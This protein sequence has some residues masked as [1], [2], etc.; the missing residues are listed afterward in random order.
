M[1][2]ASLFFALCLALPAEEALAEASVKVVRI[3]GDEGTFDWAVQESTGR[4]FASCPAREEV[5]EYDPADGKTL[6]RFRV[7]G[8]PGELLVKKDWLLVACRQARAVAVVD[9]AAN[10]V[11]GTI[12]LEGRSPD[13]LFCCALDQPFAYARCAPGE[14]GSAD[15][16]FQLELPLRTVRRRVTIRTS[17][18]VAGGPA[19]MTTDGRWVLVEARQARTSSRVWSC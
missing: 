8:A 15:E 9:L 17:S 13:A 1:P 18:K 14:D 12:R 11:A 16:V 6:R 3:A 7:E 10:E 2:I 4:V 5:V 19:H